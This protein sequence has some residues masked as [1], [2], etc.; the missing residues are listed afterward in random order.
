LE[1]LKITDSLFLVPARNGG[2]FPFAQSVYVNAERRI[3]FDAGIGVDLLR[4]FVKN[5]PVDILI[6]SH[7]HPDHIAGCG[8]LQS[9]VPIFVPAEAE[10]SFG[11][12][13]KLAARFV[14]GERETL[15]WK[16]LVT[17]VMGFKPAR[18]ARTYDG[19]AAFDLGSVKLL[20]MHTPGHTA[21]HYCFYE[22]HSGVLMLFDI[23]LSPYG[24]WY[25]HRESDLE[26][27]EA[28]VNFVRSFNAD[29]VVSSH[30][31]VLRQNVDQALARYVGRIAER[32][33]QILALIG[34]E[35]QTMAGLAGGFPFTPRHHPQLSPLYLYWETQMVKKHLDRLM[36]RG[37]V[38]IDDGFWRRR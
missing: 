22:E 7:S 8:Y 38:A 2:Q 18:A 3:L 16:K 6:V 11:D 33:E 23:D 36:E 28:S 1:L 27:L 24:P 21:D 29:V 15:L 34:K 31:G 9:S 37:A 4:D 14:E 19:R 13:D 12:L 17:G 30:M 35:P 25:G 5:H 20:A 26:R 10:D 32:D